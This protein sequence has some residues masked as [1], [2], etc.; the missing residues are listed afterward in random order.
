MSAPLT[1]KSTDRS[2][3]AVFSFSFYCDICGK[4]WVSPPVS[5]DAGGFSA[6]EHKETYQ[7]IW[8][9]E[10]KAAFEHANL[11]AHWHFNN[12]PKCGKWFCDNCCDMKGKDDNGLCVECAKK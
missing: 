4:E 3:L 9:Q 12:C 8:E 7:M 6:V 2:N 11:E 1:N 10:H 5:F